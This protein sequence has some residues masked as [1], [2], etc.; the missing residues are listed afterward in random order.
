MEFSRA[1]HQSIEEVET[2]LCEL[3]QAARKD[4]R[5]STGLSSDLFLAQKL[6]KCITECIERLPP[7]DRPFKVFFDSNTDQRKVDLL[8][9]GWLR[10]EKVLYERSTARVTHMLIIDSETFRLEERHDPGA[11][12]RSNMMVIDAPRFIAKPVLKAFDDIFAQTSHETQPKPT[13]NE[14]FPGPTV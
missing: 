10:N 5:L 3:F 4:V 6:Q 9:D 7:G 8:K 2:V 12:E 14:H 11:P 13:R 1:S